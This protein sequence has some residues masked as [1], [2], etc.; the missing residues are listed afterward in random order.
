MLIFAP[1]KI[2]L[3]DVDGHTYT[4]RQETGIVLMPTTFNLDFETDFE[5]Y[6]TEI[7]EAYNDQSEDFLE[8]YKTLR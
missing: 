5:R 1:M 8:I 7:N 2:G 6:I 3:I 4:S